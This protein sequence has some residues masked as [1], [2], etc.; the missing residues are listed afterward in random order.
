MVDFLD[1]GVFRR[2]WTRFYQVVERRQAISTGERD[3]S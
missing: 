2:D 1:V 3:D